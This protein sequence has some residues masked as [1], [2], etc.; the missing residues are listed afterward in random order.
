MAAH[1]GRLL[2]VLTV[3][4]LAFAGCGGGEEG[5]ASSSKRVFISI[6]TA[7]V[8]GGFFTMGGALGEV[9]N[10][11]PGTNGWRVTA[12]ATKGSQENIRRLIKGEIELALSN[13][14][15]TYHAVRGE[16]T[17]EQ[18]YDVRLIGSVQAGPPATGA[19]RRRALWDVAQGRYQASARNR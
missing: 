7:P 9:L 14:A 8:V 1:S 2:L 17:W 6:G 13:A 5:E 16:A 18:P 10:A 3:A 4:L 11:N 15:I 19:H 12:E